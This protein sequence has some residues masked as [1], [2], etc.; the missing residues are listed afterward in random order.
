MVSLVYSQSLEFTRVQNI[1]ITYRRLHA[2][3][4]I[5]TYVFLK[6]SPQLLDFQRLRTPDLTHLL[7]G[8]SN[9]EVQALLTILYK[10]SQSY[11]FRVILHDP[12]D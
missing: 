7:H 6:L 5:Y 3:S 8:L 10:L 1:L 9:A 2:H 11:I 12:S 4:C